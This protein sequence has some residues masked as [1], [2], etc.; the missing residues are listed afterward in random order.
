MEIFQETKPN[1]SIQSPDLTF[2]TLFLSR[3][4]S[5]I[6]TNLT[7][8]DL[9][10]DSCL[11][12][13]PATTAYQFE[14]LNQFLYQPSL[15][16]SIQYL[17]LRGRRRCLPLKADIVHHFYCHA[18]NLKSLHIDGSIDGF[19]K[20]FIKDFEGMCITCLSGSEKNGRRGCLT[21]TTLSSPSYLELHEPIKSFERKDHVEEHDDVNLTIKQNEEQQQRL[22]QIYIRI[23]GQTP[24]ANSPSVRSTVT[25]QHQ[26][27]DYHVLLCGPVSNLDDLKQGSN[28]DTKRAQNIS[29]LDS[30]EEGRIVA[31]YWLAG[32]KIWEAL[33]KEYRNL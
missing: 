17:Y 3:L 6:T 8:L 7:F 9:N 2:T 4:P 15:T 18:K 22:P 30:L 29:S 13:N 14:C 12:F 27:D 19:C 1:S 23:L 33:D 31:G 11:T 20:S 25:G 5:T 16:E 10:T 26:L 21:S 32:Q 24:L 28:D